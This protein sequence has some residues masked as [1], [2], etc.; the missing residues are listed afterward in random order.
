MK[1][2]KQNYSKAFEHTHKE[3][4]LDTMNNLGFLSVNQNISKQI[5]NYKKVANLGS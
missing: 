2:V 1:G 3:A 4:D 5:K